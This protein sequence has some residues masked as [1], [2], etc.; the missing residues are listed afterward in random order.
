MQ[1][2]RLNKNSYY[3]FTLKGTGMEPID[4]DE[5]KCQGDYEICLGKR[6]QG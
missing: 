3:Y 2:T 6:A 4:G 1:Y 5:S